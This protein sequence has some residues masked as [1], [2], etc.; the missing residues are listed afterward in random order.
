MPV[1]ILSELKALRAY[2][3]LYALVNAAMWSIAYFGVVG[4]FS[5]AMPV[6]ALGMLYILLLGP[7]ISLMG[8]FKEGGRRK[9][10]HV[11]AGVVISCLTIYAFRPAYFQ[12]HEYGIEAKFE[13]YG[14][15]VETMCKTL[16]KEK[17]KMQIFALN[18]YESFKLWPS[19][20]SPT[21][22]YGWHDDDF[23]FLNFEGSPDSSAGVIYLPPEYAMDSTKEARLKKL[24]ARHMFGPWYR[25]RD[26]DI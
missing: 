14:A 3:I 6:V 22:N 18:Q 7:A 10:I 19:Y 11:A 25:Y 15:Q 16:M 20:L 24:S 23:F 21:R 13:K 5:P 12:F 1:T 9:F 4:F 17:A 2:L 26:D 8:L